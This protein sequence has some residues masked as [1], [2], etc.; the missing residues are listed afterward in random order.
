MRC[1]ILCCIFLSV[2]CFGVSSSASYENAPSI[3]YIH[4]SPQ[5]QLPFKNISIIVIISKPIEEVMISV[6]LQG[7][8][9][10]QCEYPMEWSSKGMYILNFS[11]GNY[12]CYEFFIMIYTKEN[13]Q[14]VSES[15]RIVI[16]PSLMDQDNDGMPDWWEKKYGFS[17]SSKKDAY[18]DVDNDGFT[19]I[20]EYL[21]D[22]NP[23]ENNLLE[24]TWFRLKQN[25]YY[26]FFSLFLFVA[27]VFFSLWGM[28]RNIQWH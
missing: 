24:I 9:N 12:G 20:E 5:V 27:I 4:A 17:V 18:L 2:I 6:L 23:L 19:N 8:N 21:Y 28:R 22:M 11:I 13:T 16:S 7:P 26:I 15:Y 1:S 25:F 10:F 14:I 3:E